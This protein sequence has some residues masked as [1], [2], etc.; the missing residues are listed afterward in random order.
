MKAILSGED[1]SDGDKVTVVSEAHE[2]NDKVKVIIR[3]RP[4]PSVRWTHVR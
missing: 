3:L 4:R 2:K 1:Y